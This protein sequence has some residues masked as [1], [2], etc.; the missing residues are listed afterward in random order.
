ARRAHKKT[1]TGFAF[2]PCHQL[3]PSSAQSVR[4]PLTLHI[5]SPDPEILM[6]KNL[7]AASLCLLATPAA[8]AQASAET[9]Q[10]PHSF[11]ANVSLVSDYRFRGYTQTNL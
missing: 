3:T 4:S 2:T 9:T 6:Q 1:G 11:S 5:V 8:F 10:S 7:L